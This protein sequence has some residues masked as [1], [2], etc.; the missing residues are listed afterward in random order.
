MIEI[1]PDIEEVE[2]IKSQKKPSKR[3]LTLSRGTPEET[4]SFADHQ[5]ARIAYYDA[6]F[7]NVVC[8]KG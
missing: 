1:A 5:R 7:Y 4:I 3:L 6:I 8:V 2:T